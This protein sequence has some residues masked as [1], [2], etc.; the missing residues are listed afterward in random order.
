LLRV[1]AYAGVDVLTGRDFYL[2]CTVPF[3]PRAG[4]VESVR[5]ELLRRG[6][7]GRQPRPNASMAQLVD[8]HLS[9]AEAGSWQSMTE[10]WSRRPR[11]TR[12][13]W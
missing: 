8:Q 1:C 5:G 2:K 6:A 3:G 12:R 11:V 9:V 4:R 10:S 13:P 7:D